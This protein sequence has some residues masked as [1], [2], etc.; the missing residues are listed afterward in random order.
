MINQIKKVF[1]NFPIRF[2]FKKLEGD[3]FINYNNDD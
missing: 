3:I 2:I 1:K